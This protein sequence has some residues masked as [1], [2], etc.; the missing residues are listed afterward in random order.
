MRRVRSHDVEVELPSPPSGPTW[1]PLDRVD[2]LRMATIDFLVREEGG[3]HYRFLGDEAVQATGKRL[4]TLGS[5]PSR[6]PP[7]QTHLRRI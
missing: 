1:C 5:R 2:T 7:S 4:A 6:S 3:H